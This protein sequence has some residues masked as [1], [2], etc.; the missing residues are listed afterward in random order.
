LKSFGISLNTISENADLSIIE[1]VEKKLSMHVFENF[2]R[3]K[4]SEITFQFRDENSED[5]FQVGPLTLEF[6][7]GKIIFLIGGNGSG[8][9]T[10]AKVI[11]GL[12]ATE[13]G[14]ITLDGIKITAENRDWYRQLFSAV[15]SNYYLS[16]TLYLDQTSQSNEEIEY[17]LKKLRLDHKVKNQNGKLTTVDLSQGQRKRLALLSAWLE[18]RP[19]YIFDEWAA[20]QDP[21]FKHVFYS[22]LLIE[23]KKQGKT[24]LA[25]THDDRYFNVADK[26]LFLEYGRIKETIE[27]YSGKDYYSYATTNAVE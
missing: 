17:F 9:T 10:L 7:P 4:C 8:K 5:M 6:E 27:E 15:W 25:I 12:Y 23:M 1:T 2:N 22:E 13:C 24:I 11:A 16:D 14:E 3:L 26:V 20:D 21:V 19:F 18:D